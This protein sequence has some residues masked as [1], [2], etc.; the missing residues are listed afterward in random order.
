MCRIILTFLLLISATTLIVAQSKFTDQ[1]QK[2]T[3][4]QGKVI[5]HQS[6][7]ITDLVNGDASLTTPTT[8]ERNRPTDNTLKKEQGEE[9]SVAPQ[10][11]FGQK[12]RMNGYR[13]QVYSGGNSR[14]AKTEAAS[15]G[16]RVKSMFGELSVYT[17]FISPHWIC[18]VGDFKSYEEANEVFQQMKASGQ[19][20]EAVIV[21]SKITTYY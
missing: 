15:M 17:N 18:R 7:R 5:L 11:V 4:G 20:R 2:S 1:L 16:H 3:E 12:V 6:Q 21:K 19:F 14:K 9:G 10:P 8:T 13:I